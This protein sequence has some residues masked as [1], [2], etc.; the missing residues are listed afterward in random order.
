M[1]IYISGPMT[2]GGTVKPDF[3]RFFETEKR[4]IQQGHVVVNPARNTRKD[5]TWE[6][7]MRDDIT[8]LL[9][10]DAI[11]MLRQW[12]HSKGACLEMYIAD[13]INMTILYEGE[14]EERYA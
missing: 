7:Y 4:L 13:R 9:T 8:D 11:Y 10:C 1:R 2:L 12:R 3:T 5:G 6:E 14:E